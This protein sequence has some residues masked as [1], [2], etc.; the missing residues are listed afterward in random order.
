MS[1]MSPEFLSP[2]IQGR[3]EPGTPRLAD[4]LCR[5]LASS[6]QHPNPRGSNYS[7]VMECLGPTSTMELY[8]DPLGTPQALL[9]RPVET[10]KQLKCRE[11][12]QHDQSQED[13]G[14]AVGD[15]V[16]GV[17]VLSCFGQGSGRKL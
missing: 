12:S 1:S 4:P 2:R 10:Y 8:L 3:H 5:R 16:D 17:L 11:C 6:A 14:R 15:G 13:L 7:A 9:V